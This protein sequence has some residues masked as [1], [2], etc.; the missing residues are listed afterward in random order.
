MYIC[1]CKKLKLQFF[2]IITVSLNQGTWTKSLKGNFK[3]IV[4]KK[5]EF[6]IL[7]F[8][9]N[10]YMF[11]WSRF[12]KEI[13]H[14]KYKFCSIIIWLLLKILS[15]INT[16]KLN[17]EKNVLIDTVRKKKTLLT[18]IVVDRLPFVWIQHSSKI[19]VY[20]VILT[21]DKGV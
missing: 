21:L 5:I 13:H 9:R 11:C 1:C 7:I 20:D 12:I 16:V 2:S 15:H 10:W 3:N 4:F 17:K 14:G 6:Y 8:S 19:I 18:Y